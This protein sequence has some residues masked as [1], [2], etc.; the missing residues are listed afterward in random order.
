MKLNAK[1]IISQSGNLLFV[2]VLA[3][4]LFN[5]APKWIESFKREGTKVEQDLKVML[6]D[7]SETSLPL[8]TR[9]ALIFWATWC[10][11]CTI[12]LSRIQ[13]LVANQKIPADKIFAIALDDELDVI[14][15]ASADRGY[16]FKVAQD[17]QGQLSHALNVEVTP[18]IVFLNEKDEIY[19]MTTG[20]SPTLEFR[21]TN[22]LATNL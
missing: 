8:K 2:I 9:R 6:L 13:K 18:T 21:L 19:W 3:F 1:K 7:G 15:K 10:G 16:T 12:E 4:I 20:I 17:F 14:R 11:P 5:R 22:F